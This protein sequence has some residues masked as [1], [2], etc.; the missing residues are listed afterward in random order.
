VA[1]EIM[2][3]VGAVIPR[4]VQ[5]DKSEAG[6][7]GGARPTGCPLSAGRS[8]HLNRRWPRPP[9]IPQPMPPRMPPVATAVTSVVVVVVVFAVAVA[10]LLRAA[11]SAA[12][13]TCLLAICGT[14]LDS[15]VVVTVVATT[16]VVR[17][18]IRANAS[19]FFECGASTFRGSRVY[20]TCSACY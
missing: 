17:S 15:I 9:I 10:I 3:W 7:C 8:I 20:R 19:T 11:V 18:H 1:V 6:R 4:Q 5:A 13:R 12:Y 16:L 14:H 2:V